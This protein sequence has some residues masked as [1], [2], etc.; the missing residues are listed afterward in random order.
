MQLAFFFSNH[1]NC[2]AAFCSASMRPRTDWRV[3]LTA[4]DAPPEGLG[5]WT[6]AGLLMECRLPLLERPE[7]PKRRDPPR[8]IDSGNSL[9]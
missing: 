3:G 2:F 9:V 4:E 7:A 6:G 5:S 1:C 8:K